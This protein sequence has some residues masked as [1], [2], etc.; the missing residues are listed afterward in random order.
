MHQGGEGS[1]FEIENMASRGGASVYK[2]G[3]YRVGRLDSVTIKFTNPHRG[4]GPFS[5]YFVLPYRPS[6][7]W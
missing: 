6:I 4:A 7:D 2:G 3:D 1:G 5:L